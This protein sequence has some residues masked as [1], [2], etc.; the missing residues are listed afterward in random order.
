MKRGRQL[1]PEDLGGASA[2]DH[3]GSIATDLVGR[4]FL[5]VGISRRTK[6]SL[7][8][9]CASAVKILFLTGMSSKV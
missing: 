7:G 2:F 3:D 5:F 6:T 9:L 4:V 1:I 8:V